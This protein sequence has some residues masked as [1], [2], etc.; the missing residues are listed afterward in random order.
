M[1]TSLPFFEAKETDTLGY[2][3]SPQLALVFSQ[4]MRI[5]ASRRLIL[6]RVKLR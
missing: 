6:V 5:T 1:L 2:V 3:L 4:L